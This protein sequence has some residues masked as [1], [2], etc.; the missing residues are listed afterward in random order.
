MTNRAISFNGAMRRVYSVLMLAALALA[1]AACG[2]GGD[3]DPSPNPSPTSGASPSPTPSPTSSPTTTPT[4]TPT[5]TPSAS[6]NPDPTASP[7]PG[8]SIGAN[9]V[10]VHYKRIDNTYTGWAVYAFSGPVKPSTGWPGDPRYFFEK[11]DAYGGYVDILVDPAKSKM[12]FLLNK[13]TTGA[14]TV[15]DMD[16]DRV[17]TFSADIA[18]KG[19]EIWLKQA[20]CTTY[21]SEAAALALNLNT[22]KA[23]WLTPDTIVWP[24]A[25]TTGA[26]FKLY[27]AANGGITSDGVGINGADGTYELAPTTLSDALKA[28]F[29]HLKDAPAFTVPQA[30]RDKVK[31]LLKGQL[32]LVREAGGKPES[33]TQLQIQGVLDAVYAAAATKHT[34]GISFAPDGTPCFKLWAPTAK[35]VKLNIVGGATLD[36]VEDAASGVWSVTGDKALTNTAYYTYRVQVFSRNDNNAVVTNTVTDPYAV[37]LNTNGAAAMVANISNHAFKP[38]GW[39]AHAAPAFASQADA[40]LYE[41]HVRDFSANDPTVDAA[42]RGKFAAFTQTGSNG[43]KHLAKLASAGLTHVHLLPVYDITSVNEAG[44]VTPAI[45]AGSATST[46]QQAA[47]AAAKDTDCFNWGYDPRHY[48]APE[49]SYSS[50]AAD[51]K[52]RVMEM[53]Q[54]VQ[55]LHATGLRVVMDVVYNHTSGNFLDKIVPGYYYRLSGDGN[56]EKSTCCENT[57]TEFAMMEKLM[58]D[59]LKVWATQYKVDGF[60]FDLMGHIPKEVMTRM[61]AAVDAAAGC[62][63]VYYGEGWNFGEVANNRIFD[64]ATQNNMV[65]VGIGTFTDR[66]R[67]AIRGGGPFDGGDAI[68]KNQGFASGQCYDLNGSAGA[69]CTDAQRAELDARQ[70]WIRVGMTGNLKDYVLNGKKGSEYDYNGSPVGYAMEPLD[71]INYAG[72]HDNETLWDISQS[73][74]PVATTS[75]E[76]ARAQVIALGTIL[77]SQGTPFIHGG[78]ELLRSKSMDR[79]S[80]NAGDWFNRVDW[81]ATTNY[82][83]QMGLPSEEKNKDNWPTISPFLANA[84]ITPTAGDIAA[85]RDA[86]LDLIKLRKDTRML[87]LATGADV[88]ACVSFPD[89]A[90]QQ[91]G[92]IIMRVAGTKAAGGM[93]GDGKYKSLVVLVNANKVEQTFTAA[94]YAGK[95]VNLHPVQSAGSDARVKTASFNGAAGAFT[96]PGRTIAVFVQH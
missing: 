16:C 33:G 47:A 11:T 77:M 28:Q 55:A 72:A 92:L 7:S 79:D 89:A 80:Y 50:N 8:L 83:G 66:I 88:Q 42:Q 58:T 27:T 32:V 51:G 81:S 6:P 20:D 18:T 96:V 65:G 40:I 63:L 10:R 86:V 76:R 90:A 45:P 38:A 23:M 9:T 85:A 12:D 35:S 24:G 61:K 57:A 1:V 52:A 36:M 84:A 94:G 43:M 75:A 22:A 39:D 37:T 95:T 82:W 30:A 25:A 64:Q 14:D 29:R 41:L 78:D 3:S 19:Q 87:R 5:S 91:D 4:S 59:T 13:G 17:A 34:L 15:K 93:C 46:E 21:T 69:T 71:T 48:G 44:C 67:D 54:M 26:T 62:P 60:R 68:V 2:G 31:S 70:N 53:R 73:K 49:G 74:H 56:I